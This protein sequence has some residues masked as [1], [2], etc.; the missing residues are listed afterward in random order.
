MSN[1]ALTVEELD[2]MTAFAA[3]EGRKWK[4][5]M[6]YEYWMKGLPVRDRKGVEYPL[7]YGL[8]NTHGPSWLDGFKLPKA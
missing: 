3:Q 1:R 7:L 6:M 2:Q 4:S 5:V 8:R